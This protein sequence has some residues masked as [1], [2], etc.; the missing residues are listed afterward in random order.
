MISLRVAILALMLAV[1]G[2]CQSYVDGENRTVGEYT[3]DTQ[4]LLAVKRRLLSDPEV[5]G[6]KIRV[7]VNRAMVSLRGKVPSDYARQKALRIAGE[8]GS[9]RGVEDLLTVVE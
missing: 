8:T 9:V 1:L 4:I 7:K 3:D 2:G 6:W 5:K